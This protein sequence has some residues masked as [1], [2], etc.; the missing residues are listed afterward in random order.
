MP[1]N[2][3]LRVLRAERDLSQMDTAARAKI[4]LYRY[5]QIEN[6]YVEARP[7]ER[8]RL[9]RVFKVTPPDVFPEADAIAS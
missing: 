1:K 8:E 4:G 2:K 5:W 9:A 6:G 3:R 7:D